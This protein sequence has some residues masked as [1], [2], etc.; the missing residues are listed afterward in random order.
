[1]LILRDKTPVLK[2]RWSILL[3]VWM[4]ITEEEKYSANS[5]HDT[6]IIFRVNFRQAK[7]TSG[8]LVPPYIAMPSV[9]H[10]IFVWNESFLYVQ[11]TNNRFS[12][13]TF[14]NVIFKLFKMV[15]RLVNL[16]QWQFEIDRVFA[17]LHFRKPAKCASLQ[18]INKIS[19]SVDIW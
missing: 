9:L 8:Q 12:Y 16:P 15:T 10:N 1:M 6:T 2:S 11:Y 5:E 13:W 17:M 14:L 7:F 4:G 3:I 19:K 18:K